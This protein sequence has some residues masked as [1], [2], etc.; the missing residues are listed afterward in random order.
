MDREWQPVPQMLPRERWEILNDEQRN[1]IACI[2]CAGTPPHMVPVESV[3]GRRL[4]C[5]LPLC[6]PGRELLRE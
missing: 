6:E 4:L 3:R 2:Y 5:C 1:G